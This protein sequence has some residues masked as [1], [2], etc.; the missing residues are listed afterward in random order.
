MSTVR[1]ILESKS[2]DLW[3][4]SPR[5][6]VFEAL[7][8]MAEKDIGALLVLDGEQLVGVF[9]ERDYARKVVLQG[10]SSKTTSVGELMAPTVFYVTPDQTVEDCMAL[11][12]NKRVRHLPVLENER[13][14]G[15]VS[16]GDVVKAVIMAQEG[17]IRQLEQYITGGY[18]E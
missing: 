2:G 6:T 11:M 18:A 17:T 4:I 15:V 10:R 7:Q 5:A 14:M 1:Q 3:S 9:S 12:T 13:L 8:V 16:I